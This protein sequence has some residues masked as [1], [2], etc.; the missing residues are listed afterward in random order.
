MDKLGGKCDFLNV[1]RGL[2]FLV[3]KDLQW[4]TSFQ[5]FRICRKQ[6]E[7]GFMNLNLLLRE[8]I[9]MVNNLVDKF[10]ITRFRFAKLYYNYTRTGAIFKVYAEDFHA[11]TNTIMKNN[12]RE[13]Q[14]LSIWM[15]EVQ[16]NFAQWFTVS[17]MSKVW[18]KG[19][20]QNTIIFLIAITKLHLTLSN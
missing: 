13:W 1:T 10:P 2:T 11:T 17:K 6:K 19:T 15:N 9:A 18:T 4:N 12:V 14:K 16:A 20:H 8:M 5:I 7:V 3:L